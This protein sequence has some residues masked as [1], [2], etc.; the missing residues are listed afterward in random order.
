M[1]G[2][3]SS[4][5][6]AERRKNS[7]SRITNRTGR[8]LDIAGPRGYVLGVQHMGLYAHDCIPYALTYQKPLLLF[9]IWGTNDGGWTVIWESRMTPY[10]RTRVPEDDVRLWEQVCRLV[11]RLPDIDLGVNEQGGPIVLSCHMLARAISRR[12][13]IPYEDGYFLGHCEHSWLRLSS[14]NIIDVYPV[15]ILGGPL[16]IDKWA[17]I[18]QEYTCRGTRQMSRGR[19]GQCSFRRSVR[20][21]TRALS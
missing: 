11:A 6:S 14:G 20:R 17:P 4:C 9:C 2:R 1:R 21:I 7:F 15:G 19:F 12:T 16:L 8:E 10:V 13:G 18:A 3:Y 5:T